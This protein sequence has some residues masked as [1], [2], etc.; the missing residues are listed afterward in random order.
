MP[1]R[2]E[3]SIT[4]EL[5]SKHIQ[6]LNKLLYYFK[7]E[8]INENGDVIIEKGEGRLLLTLKD[9]ILMIER[10]KRIALELKEVS[11]IIHG[12]I[13][14]YDPSLMP[15]YQIQQL[16][17]LIYGDGNP[18]FSKVIKNLLSKMYPNL[19]DLDTNIDTHDYIKQYRKEVSQTILKNLDQI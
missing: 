4:I 10:N 16:L 1:R 7:G 15:I 13:R 14:D 18:K 2:G 5:K 11:P 12:I 8:T 19:N 6:I 17:F 3:K 9:L